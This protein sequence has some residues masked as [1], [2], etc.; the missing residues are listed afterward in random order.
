MNGSLWPWW[1]AEYAEEVVRPRDPIIC[2]GGLGAPS[3]WC[4]NP[5]TVVVTD[6]AGMQCFTCDEHTGEHHTE[7]IADWFK[8]LGLPVPGVKH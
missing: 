7:A 1:S 4:V 6:S 5:A 2:N 8:K 3:P